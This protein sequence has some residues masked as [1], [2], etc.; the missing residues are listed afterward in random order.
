MSQTVWITGASSGIGKALAL[1]YYQEG[2]N[3]VLSARKKEALDEVAKTFKDQKRVLVLPLDLSQ[4]ESFESEVS[5]VLKSFP[6]ID[7]LINNGGISQRAKAIGTELPVTK[8]L[9]NVNFFG[10]VAL[11]QE[12]LKSMVKKGKGKIVVI[13]SLVGKFGTP[14]RSSYSA[15]KHALHGYFDSLRAELPEEIKVLI[16]CP[17]F[18]NTNISIN[19]LSHDGHSTGVMDEAQDKAMSAQE[20]AKKAFIRIEKS[21]EESYIGGKEIL[22]VYLKR[23]F[24][25]LF[26]RIIRI[27]KVN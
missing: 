6:S 27:A 19:A 17:G 22:G 14:L 25:G 1:K 26:S 16:I 8:K 10:T 9:M 23:F 18:V 4:N 15:S 2:F 11:T 7:I 12:V 3:I 13:S 21:K 24:P 20:F 5:Q